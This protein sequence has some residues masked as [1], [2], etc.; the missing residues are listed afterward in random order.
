M[1]KV[2]TATKK[3]LKLKK[4]I[5][6]IS[7]GTGASKTYSIMMIL[8]DYAQ[9]NRNKKI[10]VVSETHTHLVDGALKD[11]QKIMI[12]RKYW[13]DSRWNRSSKE[14]TF[15]TGSTIK[16]LSFDRLGKAHGPRRDVLFLNEAN[17]VHW[18][19]V[20]QLI[21]R[22]RETVWIDWNPTT[23]F[24]F[25]DE[26][27]G[28][29]D[30]ID[31]MGERGNLPP[32]TFKDNE[33]LSEGEK[34]EILIRKPNKNWWRVYGLGLLGEIESRIFTNWK[35]IDEIPHEARLKRRYLDFGYKNDPSA[36]GEVYEFNNGWIVNELLYRKGMKNQQLAEFLNNLPNPEILVVA[37]SAEPKSIDEIRA[38]GVNVLESKKGKDSVKFGIQLVEDQPISVTKN[39]YNIWKEYRNYIYITDRDGRIINEPDP[40]CDDHHMDGIRYALETLGRIKQEESYW[41]KIFKD[42][43]HP[44]NT[45]EINYDRG[46]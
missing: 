21:T 45:E 16:F 41:D 43:L 4:K 28:K 5:R 42:E 17:Y 7:G 35:S 8:I 14:Y 6:A 15:E 25:Y 29:R 30:D 10:D 32:L 23:E 24:W 19:I 44:D 13:V 46:K 31:F 22:T 1:T 38:Y 26:M 37:D 12:D 40:L 36:I 2:T 33:G 18:D 34:Q 39:S 11:F 3:L 27:L 20:N 9:S